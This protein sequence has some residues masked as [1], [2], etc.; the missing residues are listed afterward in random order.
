MVL[1]GWCAP[2]L[3]VAVLAGPG[4]YYSEPV[5][6]DRSIQA[7]PAGD[8]AGFQHGTEGRDAGSSGD[9]D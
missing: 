6:E 8:R 7:S 1:R 9:E 3:C 2:A 4:C 5:R